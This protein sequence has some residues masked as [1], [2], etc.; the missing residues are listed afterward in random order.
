MALRQD[1]FVDAL[2]PR[3]KRIEDQAYN[4][5]PDV[6][7]QIFFMDPGSGQA[8]ERYSQEGTVGELSDFTGT[9]TYDD[10]FEGYRAIITPT[11]KASGL[12]IERKLMENVQSNLFKLDQKPRALGSGAYRT[13]QVDGARLFNNAFSNDTKWLS[14]SEG[15][16]L[17]SNSHTTRSGASTAS[18]FDNLVT[19]ALSS[20]ALT[21]AVI[22][23]RQFRGDR[24]ERI[25][26][27]ADEV[28][29]PVDLYGTAH[30]I[31]ESEGVPEDV[32]NASNVHYQG[33]KSLVPKG[34][35]Y[36]TDTANWFLMDS[37]MRKNGYG[38]IWIDKV[39]NEFAFVE[40]IDTLMGKWRIYVY[41]GMGYLNWRWCLGANVS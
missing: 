6:I 29:H 26:I 40:D 30:E 22:Q 15:V 33:Y 35:N 11:E 38:P 34:W 9:V 14:H 3:F 17:C 37:S 27:M 32:I 1:N 10:T 13:R 23:M 18:G 5:I 7:P 21:A 31:F 28:L 24:A 16:P 25:T 8:S 4:E 39:K 19:S 12:Q 2:D 20:T 36:L 41:Y